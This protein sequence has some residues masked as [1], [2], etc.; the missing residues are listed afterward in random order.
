[1]DE[2]ANDLG[3][4]DWRY[5]LTDAYGRYID[6]YGN[7]VETPYKFDNDKFSNLYVGQTDPSKQTVNRYTRLTDDPTSPYYNT[8]A[9]EI[10]YQ[11][12]GKTPAFEGWLDI[13]GN[14]TH[15]YINPIYGGIENTVFKN[16]PKNIYNHLYIIIYYIK[17]K[18]YC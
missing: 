8:Y 17:I 15:M 3:V 16:M 18:K 2:S 14:N 1:M 4:R 10:Q 6:P 13:G 12:D 7:V 5:V 9:D 11:A